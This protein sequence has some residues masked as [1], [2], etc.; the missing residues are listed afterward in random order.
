MRP[1]AYQTGEWPFATVPSSV[2]LGGVRFKR[3]RWSFPVLGAL[4]Q[5]REDRPLD[6]RH[7]FVWGDRTW[8]IGHVDAYNPD[9]HPL[10]HFVDTLPGRMVT[11]ASRPLRL[12]RSLW[13]WP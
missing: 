8:S 2:R 3:S 1:I 4:A 9:V 6:S 5:Y 11:H 12:L 7:L 13:P 10:K